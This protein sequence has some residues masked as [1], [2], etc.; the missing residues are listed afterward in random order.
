[1]HA[2][3]KES[4][5]KPDSIT[6]YGVS[7]PS[8][9]EKYPYRLIMGKWYCHFFSSILDQI[10]CI[11]AGNDDILMSSDDFKI[12]PDPIR[13]HRI[14]GSWASKKSMLPFFRFTV[15]DIPGI[16]SGERLQNHWSSS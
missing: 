1:M 14:S 6:D 9:S 13:D 8:Q 15:V 4:Q 12:R 16:Y 2:S 11:L 7:C 5:N 10:F 3:S